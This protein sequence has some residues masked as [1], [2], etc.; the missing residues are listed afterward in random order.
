METIDRRT[1]IRAG[2]AAGLGLLAGQ[3]V[4]R[5]ATTPR[6]GGVLRV[7]TNMPATEVPDP[8]LATTQFLAPNLF[9]PPLRADPLFNLRP[10]GCSDWS[11]NRTAS[12]WT[13]SVR[14]GA[15]FST[16]RPLT[17]A[18]YAYSIRRLLDP[19]TLSPYTSSI[20]PY[21]AQSGIHT[22]DRHTLRLELRRPNAF[23]DVLLA[24]QEF[25]AVPAGWRTG[26]KPVGSGPFELQEFQAGTNAALLANPR[27]WR[28][29]HPHV[30]GI[31]MVALPQESARLQSLLGGAVDI[32]D[33]LATSGAALAASDVA[34]PVVLRGGSWAGIHLLGNQAPFTDPRVVRA[35]QL[36]LNR[37]LLLQ[38][39]SSF[40]HHFVTPDFEVVPPGDLFYPV[41]LRPR[42][43][44]PEQA[45]SLLAQAGLGNGLGFS[46][47]CA[48][49]NVTNAIAT[50]YQFIA[51][52]SNISV[53]VVPAPGTIF[54]ATAPGD[55]NIARSGPRQHAVTALGNN[56]FT[57]GS[58]NYTHYS[59]A[60]FDKLYL[61]LLATPNDEGAQ[62]G[63]IADMCHLITETWAGA[64]AGVFDRVIGRSKRVQGLHDVRTV[65]DDVWLS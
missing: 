11:P 33:G 45:R 49:G 26:S 25:G 6:R 19:A 37:L 50:T 60:T 61:K 24:G 28:A 16:G 14:R 38:T 63:L 55:Q 64:E 48:N 30:D 44:D 36:S 23:L 10:A 42:K 17:S 62:K 39:T 47:Y 4:G 15:V 31:Q 8:A 27:Y 21:L 53:D 58:T 3:A 5:A 57:G 1:L 20:A 32:A 51:K 65:L 18:D 40:G 9:D 46:L 7:G 34:F 12:T 22:P 2:A 56:Y 41:G 54:N 43:Y 52:A 13:F 59:N 35:V 29:G